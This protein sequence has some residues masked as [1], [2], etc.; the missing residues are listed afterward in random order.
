[1]IQQLVE[2]GERLRSDLRGSMVIHDAL[3]EEPVS[4]ECI[5]DENGNFIE[6]RSFDK[7]NTTTEAIAAKKGK[8]RLLVDK[9][10][11]VLGYWDISESS[12]K[13]QEKL[14]EA[15]LKKHS[16]FL[17]KLQD[18]EELNSISPVLD[19]YFK[20]QT[21]GLKKALER[22]PDSIPEKERNGN[23]A[24]LVNGQSNRL[25]EESSVIQAL[26]DR[27][28]EEQRK[29]AGD[30]HCSVCG[31]NNYPVVALPHGMIKRVPSGQTSG[32]ALVSYNENAYESYGF[33]GNDNSS[34]CTHCA[35]LYVESLNW[36]MQNGRTGFDDKGK[37][38]FYYTN[39]KKLGD[40]TALVF[41]TKSNT[42]VNELLLLDEP[43]DQEIKKLIESVESGDNKYLT[44]NPD[45]FYAL[46]LSG[47]AA[48]IAIRDWIEK[49]VQQVHESIANWFI[50]IGT[51]RSD[52]LF[53][54][55][56]Y[57]MAKSC[58][59][60]KGSNDQITGRVATQLWQAALRNRP[61]PLWVLASVIG[62]IKAEQAEVTPSRAA[63][64]KLILNRKHKNG[65]QRYMEK[66]DEHNKEAAYIFGRI[67]SVLESIQWFALGETNAGIRERHFSSAATTPG[68]AFGRLMNLAQKHLTKLKSDKPGLAVNLDRE[69]NELCAKIP[70]PTLPATFRLEEQ[71][72]FAL[73]YYHQKNK[74]YNHDKEE[75]AN[76]G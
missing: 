24:F 20:N 51:I 27:Y 62:R 42:S 59:N 3:K 60:P 34:I 67:F 55:P 7:K 71:G 28:E 8:A 4:I 21:A 23:I 2:L 31:T 73:G 44:V 65:G 70:G 33:S 10:E 18:Y 48:R 69:L 47:A 16:L 68:L 76:N 9:P 38:R 30:K 37:E 63:L 52:K 54:A 6:F 17:A 41:W 29:N 15:A 5:I 36:L 56:I 49:S 22:F 32:C 1:M 74:K 26:I 53:Y 64:I 46:S 12:P 14:K 45:M 43:D 61:I 72:S 66:L 58:N 39:R 75:E 11:E 25:H 57:Q 50:D 40:D 35:K 19:F 13:K